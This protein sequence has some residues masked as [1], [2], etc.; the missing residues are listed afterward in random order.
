MNWALAHLQQP[1]SI[2]SAC[3]PVSKKQIVGRKQEIY[4]LMLFISFCNQEMETNCLQVE[5]NFSILT[6][7]VGNTMQR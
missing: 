4:V 6:V 2:F 5:S 1:F 7:R 3:Q